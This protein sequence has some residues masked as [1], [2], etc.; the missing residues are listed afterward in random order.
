MRN[1]VML[2]CVAFATSALAGCPEDSTECSAPQLLPSLSPVNM[3]NMQEKDGNTVDNPGSNDNPPFTVNL[4][5][6]SLCTESVVIDKICMVGQ[7]DNFNLR[8]PEPSTVP[9]NQETAVEITYDRNGSG[10]VEQAAL[11]I[12]SNATN[13][14]TMVIPVCAR[15]VSDAA[16]AETFLCESPVTVAEGT[17][18]DTLCAN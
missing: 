6:S 3:G 8:G 7:S 15:T 1:F 18:D 5:L 12:Q 2:V 16:D 4:L 13:F 10:G 11:V 9:F 14:P 17:K